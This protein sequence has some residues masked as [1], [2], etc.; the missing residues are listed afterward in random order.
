VSLPEARPVRSG[1]AP[2]VIT[3]SERNPETQ[4]W[5]AVLALHGPIF[6]RLNRALNREFGITLAKFDVLAQLYR[7]PDGLTQ[8]E[9]SRHLKVTDGNTTGLVRRLE[10]DGLIAR[11]TSEADRRA[12]IVRLTAEGRRIYL[13]AR[14][15]HDALLES[16]LPPVGT[17]RLATLRDDL[18]ELARGLAAPPGQ[19]QP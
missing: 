10:A 14:S 3:R 2:S 17:A 16:L 4:L 9:L 11:E 19:E 5:H 12:F 18:M 6:S 7:N 1:V 13:A 8:S 15:H